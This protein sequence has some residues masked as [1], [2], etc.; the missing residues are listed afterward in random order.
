MKKYQKHVQFFPFLLTC[1]SL[2]IPFPS[3]GEDNGQRSH[4]SGQGREDQNDRHDGAKNS[5]IMDDQRPQDSSKREEERVLPPRTIHPFS[6][7][8]LAPLLPSAMF[9]LLARL[10]LEA[11]ATYNGQS[12]FPLAYPQAVGC[13][14][15]G[16]CRA[17]IS[18]YTP[19]LIALTTGQSS[20]FLFAQSILLK[21]RQ[22][23]AAQ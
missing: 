21:V 7:E 6:P 22:V 16:F 20:V 4:E 13:L 5:L 2:W 18:G 11:L 14:I 3:K 9:G 19:L 8:V 23:S 1:L 12:I 17:S 10:G 15:M